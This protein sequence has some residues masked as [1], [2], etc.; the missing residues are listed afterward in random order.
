M[1]ER[2]ETLIELYRRGRY[3]GLKIFDKQ[4]E[5]LTYLTDKKTNDVLYGGAAG[6]G[7]SV[8]GC[9]WVLMEAL[10]KPGSSWL[11]AREELKK[12][13]DTTM[14]TFWG[15][16]SA[17]N[18]E[19][20]VDYKYRENNQSF[21]L[22]NGSR[23]LFREIKQIPSDKEFDRFGSYDL[24]GAFLDEAQELAEKVISVLRGRFRVLKGDG[25]HTIPKMYMSCNP[26]KGWIYT[27]FYKP[28]KESTIEAWRKFV[29]ALPTDNPH[30]DPAYLENLRKGDYITVQRLYYG[31]WEYDDEEGILVP[32]DKALNMFTNTWVPP[33]ERYIS[34]DIALQGSDK[35]VILVWSGFRV[36]DMVVV[37]KSNAKDVEKA[38]ATAQNKHQVPRS[39]IVYD[40]DGIGSYLSAYFTG[41]VSFRNNAAPIYRGNNKNK[42]NYK[43]L[44]S[45]C[46]FIGSTAITE[47]QVYFQCDPGPH[48]DNIVQEIS[49][50]KNASVGT[51][52]P[53]A[54][55]KK[56]IWKQELK[57]SPDYAD[58]FYMR[59]YFELAGATRSVKQYG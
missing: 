47:G 55:Q 5:A 14:E 27:D 18:L 12:L 26:A 32:Y 54:I 46:F 43:N 2:T 21:K 40:G 17:L 29:Q 30:N 34:A 11:V 6:G 58:A 45:Q 31:N 19:A 59:W 39:Q 15:E 38:L 37:N 50:A 20:E 8:L 42:P 23:I 57:R 24:T 51:D 1:T 52:M 36:I 33:G 4:L 49:T 3:A 28:N 35:F 25:W 10:S 56:E 41:A 7:K 44:K 16:V 22:P 48:K 53:L 13:K 9:K